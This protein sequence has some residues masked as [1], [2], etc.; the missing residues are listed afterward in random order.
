MACAATR[1]AVVAALDAL[2]AAAVHE[3]FDFGLTLPANAI[4]L[5][6]LCGAALAAGVTGGN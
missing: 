1:A 2:V 6:V 4:T 3:L 5:A